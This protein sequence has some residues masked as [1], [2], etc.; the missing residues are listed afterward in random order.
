M[1]NGMAVETASL[2][3]RATSSGFLGRA[4]HSGTTELKEVL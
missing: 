3:M 4:M 1:V 2:I